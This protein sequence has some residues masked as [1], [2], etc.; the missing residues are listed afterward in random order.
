MH[1]AMSNKV[2]VLIL[3]R[4]LRSVTDSLVDAMSKQKHVAG[5]FVVDSGSR[6]EEIS[7]HTVIGDSSHTAFVHGLR[8]NRGFNLGVS[9]WLQN[10]DTS[11]YLLLLPN[12]SELVAWNIERLLDEL[13]GCK[14]IGAVIPLPPNDPYLGLLGED[15]VGIGW[16]F[17]EGPVLFT[18]TFLRNRFAL[19]PV[20]DPENFRGYLSFIDLAFQMYSSNIGILASDLIQFSENTSILINEFQLMGTEP[21]EENMALL[22]SEGETWLANKY[23]TKERWTIELATRLLFEEFLRVNPDLKFKPLL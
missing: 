17:H 12:D 13:D 7:Q 6:K 5:C 15:S 14:G 4:N 1:S 21:L 19:G 9:W 18:R 23:G 3:N 8:P 11:D 10:R 2:D 16:N 22:V 20:F